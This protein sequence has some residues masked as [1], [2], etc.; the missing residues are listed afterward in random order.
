MQ[1]VITLKTRIAPQ[2]NKS[3][4]ISRQLKLAIG[5]FLT[6][7]YLN[8]NFIRQALDIPAA[9]FATIILWH[10]QISESRGSIVINRDPK[11]NADESKSEAELAEE[12]QEG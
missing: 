10:L 4:F 1:V 3:V 5:S 11:E 8:W 12:W 7:I 2:P 6:K 9:S